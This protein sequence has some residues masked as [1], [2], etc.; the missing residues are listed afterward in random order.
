LQAVWGAVQRLL[1]QQESSTPPQ[2][3]HAPSEQVPEME[4]PQAFP[5]AMQVGVPVP[6]AAETQQPPSV[7]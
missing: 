1:E 7:Q 5:D 6:L 2:L 4:L 3:P